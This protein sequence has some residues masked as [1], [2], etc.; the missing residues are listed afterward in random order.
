MAG[1]S[2]AEC[3]SFLGHNLLWGRGYKEATT[4]LHF[5][6]HRERDRKGSFVSLLCSS[7]P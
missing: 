3:N 2:Q 1:N 6:G 5:D 7:E 4:M